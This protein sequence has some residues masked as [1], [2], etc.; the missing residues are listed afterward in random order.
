MT[1]PTIAE[2]LT[3]QSCSA[4]ALTN[5][6]TPPPSINRVGTGC[7]GI[8]A[9]WSKL[10]MLD[11]SLGSGTINC[12]SEASKWRRYWVW[13]AAAGSIATRKAAQA[14]D[15]SHFGVP[16]GFDRFC[17]GPRRQEIGRAHV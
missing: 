8:G 13:V 11:V 16:S 3:L 5:S 4:A 17:P 10:G 14:Q 12:A 6:T 9:A 15:R 2:R 7:V 1:R